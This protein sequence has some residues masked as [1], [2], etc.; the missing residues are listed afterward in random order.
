MSTA[1]L[2]PAAGDFDGWDDAL[3][4]ETLVADFD[5]PH[6]PVRRPHGWV[7]EREAIAEGLGFRRHRSREKEA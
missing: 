6:R 3:Q 5:E 2:P 7:S 1:I 4:F